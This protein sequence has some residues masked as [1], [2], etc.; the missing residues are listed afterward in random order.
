M[1][2]N[3]GKQFDN[4]KFLT[5]CEQFGIRKVF[6]SPGH[7]Q[8]NG[9]V[10]AAN[11]TIKENLKKNLEKHK[12]AWID[13]LPRV[14][15]AYRTTKR[16][17]TGETPFTMAFGVEVVIPVEVGLPELDLVEEKREQALIRTTARNQVVARYY[18]KKF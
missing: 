3:N 7:L 6:S 14:L 17:A 15:W 18:D 12:G 2:T 5:F 4:P 13:E 11:E 9:Q 1:V 8:S 16:T 10:E